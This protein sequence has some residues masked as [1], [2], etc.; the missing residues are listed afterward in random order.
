MNIINNIYVFLA[1]IWI[2]DASISPCH[3]LLCIST[4]FQAH[5]KAGQNTFFSHF[6]P[7]FFISNLFQWFHA[8]KSRKT[9][10]NEQKNSIYSIF[11]YSSKLVNK[12]RG[13]S[14][15][16]F[17]TLFFT[18]FHQF[19]VDYCLILVALIVLYNVTP[20]CQYR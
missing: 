8:L 12:L 6:K 19:L 13:T 4:S 9:S 10:K 1:L 14:N 18:I 11:V 16:S 5:P 7:F 2:A 20:N 3:I 17:F 15:L